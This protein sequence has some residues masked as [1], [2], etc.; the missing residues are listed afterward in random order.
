MS[1]RLVNSSAIRAAILAAAV[2][3]VVGCSDRSNSIVGVT[4]PAQTPS[5][6]PTGNL[7]VVMG[8]VDENGNVTL[9]PL[10]GG[11]G[12]GASGVDGSVHSASIYGTQNVN[13]RI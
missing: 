1:R 6:L 13:V 5:V 12:D 10:Q 7:G 4:P 3:A 8:S 9:T 11:E 2:V